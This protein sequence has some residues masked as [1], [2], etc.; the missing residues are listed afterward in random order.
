MEPFPP[1]RWLTID[2]YESGKFARDI[3]IPTTIIEAENDEIIPHASTE[4][5]LSRFG[6]GIATMT[7][8]KGVGHNDIEMN[9]KYAETLQAAVK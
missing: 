2:T 3:S 7:L 4:K 5:L 1:V 8:I 9:D 6:P